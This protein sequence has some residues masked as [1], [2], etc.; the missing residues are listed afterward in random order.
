MNRT[1]TS[2]V[3]QFKG[4]TGIRRPNE[5]QISL[6]QM[7]GFRFNTSE[8]IGSHWVMEYTRIVTR[9][10]SV[11]KKVLEKLGK[12]FKEISSKESVLSRSVSASASL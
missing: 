8:K 11:S 2:Q 1:Y 5:Q 6:M 10:E 4:T 3:I 9:F 7:H 12:N